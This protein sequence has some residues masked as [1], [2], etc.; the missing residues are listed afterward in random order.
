MN[1]CA[2][3]AKILKPKDKGGVSW[4]TLNEQWISQL[5]LK[6]VLVELMRTLM[7]KELNRLTTNDEH[8]VRCGAH[9]MEGI[10]E[11]E[12]VIGCYMWV[13]WND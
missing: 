7:A 13:R 3:V 2:W 6:G 5:I 10:F 11:M 9:L 12:L 1:V 8:K 4:Y